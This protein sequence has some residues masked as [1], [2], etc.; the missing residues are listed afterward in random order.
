MGLMDK[1]KQVGQL[2]DMRKQAQQMQKALESEVIEHTYAGGAIKI[3]IRGD[4]KI[5]GI[6]IDP[7]W[8]ANQS[9]DKVEFGLKDAVNQAMFEAQ[10]VAMKKLQAMGGGFG[11]PGM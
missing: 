1:A 7:Q 10:K 11:L 9:H 4:Q 6:T 8:I 3:V 2:N 5:Q